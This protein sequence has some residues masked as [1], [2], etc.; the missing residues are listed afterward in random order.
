MSG[1]RQ[2]VLV[3]ANVLFSR[4]LRDWIA[5]VYL[6][7]ELFDVKWTEDIL[8]EVLYNLRKR[9]P[10]MPGRTI[11]VLR[12]RIEETFVNGR[13][14][15]FHI[16]GSFT[17]SDLHDAHVHA[18]AVACHADI[19]LTE[20]GSDF[21]T[22]DGDDLPYEVYSCDEFLVLIDDSAPAVVRAA[23]LRQLAYHRKKFDAVNLPS[24]LE[25]AGAPNFAA[26]VRRRL[27]ELEDD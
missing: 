2:V 13:V 11:S 5:I 26:R 17:G 9:Y 3:D 23:I 22:A 4:T 20:N 15:D 6:E 16:D 18:A 21:S 7:G 25:L 8:A 10:D 19:I 14:E 1:W 24:D 12:E 27:L